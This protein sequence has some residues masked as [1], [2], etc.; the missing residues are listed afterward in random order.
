[1]KAR[2][3]R[4]GEAAILLNVKPSVLR[5]WETEFQQLIPIR[6]RKGQRMYSEQNVMLLKAIRHLLYERGLT[7]EGARKVLGRYEEKYGS[8]TG[9]DLPGPEIEAFCAGQGAET[10]VHS[11]GVSGVNVDE[12]ISELTSLRGMLTTGRG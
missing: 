4:I 3:Y 1:M 9:P 12:I 7:I 11:A 10:L 6:T 2:I 8:I 5:F